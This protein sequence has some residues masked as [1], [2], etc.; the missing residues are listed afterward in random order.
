MKRNIIVGVL[1]TLLLFTMLVAVSATVRANGDFSLRLTING[2]DISQIETVAIDA[3]GEFIID[4]RIFDTTTEVVL[5]E[6][7]VAVTFAGQVILTVSEPL[8]NHRILPGEEY[9]R[10]IPVN[11]RELLHLGDTTLTTGIYRSQVSLEYTVSGH[12]EVWS[13]WTNIQVLGNPLATPV[14]G[15]GIAVSAAT[16]GALLWLSKGLSSLWKFALGRLES[17]A[18]GRV[19]GSIVSTAGKYIVGEVCPVCGTR[20]K[21]N[22]CFTCKKSAKVIRREYRKKLKDLALQGEKLLDDGEATEDELSS[23]L[24]MSDK[25]TADVLAIIRNARLFRIRKY[26]RGLMY[27]AIFAGI[28]FGISTIIW[29]TVGGFAALSTAALVAILIAAIVIPLAITWGL[30]IRAKHAIE[31]NVSGN[32]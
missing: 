31:R 2:D 25:E 15:A 10:E 20:F 14:G 32:N 21:N 9:R 22:Y 6:L 29:V 4:L 18:R 24:N 11:A 28:G 8:E 1:F 19:V 23:K 13:G 5:R 30:R 3:N 12:E 17:L 7:S 16:L 27:R 26:S